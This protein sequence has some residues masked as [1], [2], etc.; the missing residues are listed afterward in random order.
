MQQTVKRLRFHLGYHKVALTG[1]EAR[2]TGREAQPGNVSRATSH[3]RD[4][5]GDL[6]FLSRRTNQ[7]RL[8]DH[9]GW[10]ATCRPSTWA[11][12]L[13]PSIVWKVD[14]P[15]LS[16]RANSSDGRKSGVRF[17]NLVWRP[18]RPHSFVLRYRTRCSQI[19][20]N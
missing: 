2:A 4:I 10:Q 14:C 18:R 16:R 6:P 13:V 17:G 5:A 20:S 12:I 7:A 3:S 15:A 19:G 1:L 11:G 9:I 8:L